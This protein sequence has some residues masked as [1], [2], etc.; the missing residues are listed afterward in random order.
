M[1]HRAV[2]LLEGS[3]FRVYPP[4]GKIGVKGSGFPHIGVEGSGFPHIVT[5]EFVVV[6]G[7]HTSGYASVFDVPELVWIGLDICGDMFP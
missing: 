4:G 3:G 7:F 1:G 2:R 5:M 6:R